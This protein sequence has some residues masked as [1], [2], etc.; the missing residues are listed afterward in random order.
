MLPDELMRD[1]ESTR[2]SEVNLSQPITVALQLCLVELLRSW[3][4]MPSAVTSHSSG[5]IAAA[6]A[7]GRLSFGEALG[8]A[9]WRGELALRNK[10]LR[11]LSGGMMAVRLSADDV[12]KYITDTPVGKVVVACVNSPTSVTLSGDVVALDEVRTRLEADG[13]SP[14]KLD[15]PLA[16]HSHHM[17]AMGQEY[18]ERLKSFLSTNHSSQEYSGIRFAS[19]VTGDIV[20]PSEALT[21][22]HWTRNLTNTVLFSEALER[23]CFTESGSTEVDMI[24]EIG[25]HSTLAGPIR[26]ILKGRETP[27]ASCLQRSVNAVETM[28]NLACE[29]IMRGHPVSLRSINAPVSGEIHSFLHDLPTYAWNHTSR[30]WMEPRISREM[31]HKKFEPHELLGSLLPGDN[32]L[33]PTWRNFLRLADIPWLVDHQLDS[34]VVL[35]TAAYISMAVEAVRLVRGLRDKDTRCQFQLRDVH[36]L[37]GLGIPDSSAG[38][39]VQLNL[40][41]VEGGWY[42]FTISSLSSGDDWLVNC[43]GQALA[44]EEEATGS[45]N[46]ALA[47]DFV[48]SDIDLES[49]KADVDSFYSTLAD[50]GLSYGPS[51]RSLTAISTAGSKSITD[52]EVSKTVSEA[53]DY[54]FIHPATLDSIMQSAYHG[55]PDEVLKAFMVLPQ[56]IDSILIGTTLSRQSGEQ[57]QARTKTQLSDKQAFTSEISAIN[58]GSAEE[59]PAL[60]MVGLLA[61]ALPRNDMSDCHSLDQQPLT[62]RLEWEL[63]AWTGIPPVLKDSMRITLGDEQA[64]FEKNMMRLSYYLIHDAVQELQGS[65]AEVMTTWQPHHNRLLDWMKETVVRGEAGVLSSR[66]KAWSRAG[67]GAKQILVDQMNA[68]GDASARLV[69]RVGKKLAQIVRGEI[70]P[71]EVMME[72]GG[73]LL[74]QYY[75]DSPR[76]K[77]RTYKHLSKVA[78]LLS[79]SHPGAKILEIGAGTGGATSVV[80]EAFSPKSRTSAQGSLVGHY[81]FTDVSSAFFEPAKAKFAAWIH[82]MDFKALDIEAESKRQSIAEGSYDIIVASL[83]LHA[84]KSLHETMSNVRR[85]LKPGGK[86]ILVEITTDRLDMQL[87]SGT[88]PGWWLGKEPD[89]KESPNVP[90]QTWDRVLRDAGFTGIDFDIGDCEEAEFQCTSL[91]VSTAATNAPHIFP[92]SISI[93]QVGTPSSG[94]FAWAQQLSEAI[95]QRIGV[96]PRLESFD[97]VHDWTDKVCIFA[98][99]MDGPFVHGM[100]KAVFDN[101]RG[102]L[103]RSRGLLWVSCGG[104]M[105]AGQ[106]SYA[107]VQGLLRTVRQEDTSKRIVQLDFAP[108][109]DGENWTTDQIHHIIDIFQRNFDS[110]QESVDQDNEFSVRDSMTYVPR[111][112]PN[113]DVQVRSGG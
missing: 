96:T 60:H 11:S 75:M 112:Y 16:Y 88:F 70:T 28:Q 74:H 81:T 46:E 47:A 78:R 19:P 111:V 48:D 61:R 58:K 72:A 31:R 55:V 59:P 21:P 22:E 89:R 69:I 36:F 50:G 68:S 77:D 91:I 32:G 66:S 63:D 104:N 52:F 2:V 14:R 56:S 3:N 102:L 65:S 13:I 25:A 39:E 107:M 30:Y 95:H 27:Y 42:E 34:Q 38:I 37:N 10:R 41:P 71:V 99:E 82:L 90:L 9:Y 6:Y 103:T 1:A 67:K 20:E 23:M 51:F 26:Q 97:H 29:L 84:T 105:C 40:R 5:E 109:K 43:K 12:A 106:P 17:L 24:L 54:Y 49:T 93:V 110:S 35:P 87:V 4:I 7:A 85:L 45:V 108:N 92:T 113:M 44:V 98:A 33:F 76:L 83:V 73:N 62:S 15:V 94:A 86:L 57:L 100:N 79:I 8:V 18:T 80:L 64:A 53:Q 101:L